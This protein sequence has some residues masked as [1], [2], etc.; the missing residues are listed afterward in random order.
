MDDLNPSNNTTL[1]VIALFT[2][3]VWWYVASSS[4]ATVTFPVSL[5][6]R[7][8]ALFRKKND[9]TGEGSIRPPPKKKEKF[10]CP[11][12]NETTFIQESTEH[13]PLSPLDRFGDWTDHPQRN[14]VLLLLEVS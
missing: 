10:V 6:D 9:D 11:F 12:S 1:A 2:V 8:L 3:F 5:K 14:E 4:E 13:L 7:G